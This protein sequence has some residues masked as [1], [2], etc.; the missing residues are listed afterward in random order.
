V[1]QHGPTPRLPAVILRDDLVRLQHA[2]LFLRLPEVTAQGLSPGAAI[3]VDIIELDEL[4]LQASGRFAGL[5][6]ADE[7]TIPDIEDEGGAA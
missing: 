6:S 4:E 5:R 1:A 3:W 2:P 7:A